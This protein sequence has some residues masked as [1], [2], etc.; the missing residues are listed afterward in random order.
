MTINIAKF[1]INT[2]DDPFL[3][4]CL[5]IYCCGCKHNCNGCQNPE[6]QSFKCCGKQYSIEEI[7]NYIL[8]RS[9]LVETVVFLGG[10]FYFHPEVLKELLVFCKE[11]GKKSVFYTGCK[12]ENLDENMLK[13]DI[14][15]D[16]KYDIN[17]STNHFPSS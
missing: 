13:A 5:S 15:I 9:D 3:S 6:L 14:I 11:I 7:K 4:I 16:G 10:D 17:L 12:Y 2:I 8:E 1:D